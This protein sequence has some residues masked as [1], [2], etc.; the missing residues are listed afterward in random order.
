M[1]AGGGIPVELQ[2]HGHSS[3][4]TKLLD[5]EGRNLFDLFPVKSLSFSA[6]YE[7]PAELVLV[8]RVERNFHMDAARARFSLEDLAWL[9]EA[10]GMRVVPI[11]SDPGDKVDP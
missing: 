7:S 1:S 6:G 11:E 8:L 2:W 4:Q 10:H 3:A 9:A 5:D